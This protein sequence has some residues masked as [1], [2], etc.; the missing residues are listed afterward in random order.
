MRLRTHVA[1]FLVGLFSLAAAAAIGRAVYRRTAM[2]S[3]PVPVVV[4]ARDIEAYRVI[5]EEDVTVT[6]MAAAV[7]ALGVFR[8]TRDVVGLVARGH[9]PQGVPVL[10][11]LVATEAPYAAPEQA[12]LRLPVSP[13]R[14]PA[15]LRPG[16]RLDL[17]NGPRLL[18]RDVRVVAVGDGELTVAV[19]QRAVPEVLAAAERGTLW[20]VVAPQERLPVPSPTPT[21]TPTAT[22]TAT[23]T[24]TPTPT[25]TPTP[26]PVPHVRVR[27]DLVQRVNVR[28]GPGMDFP[29]IA[30]AAPGARF[31]LVGEEG[32]WTQVCCVG[33]VRGWIRSDLLED[34]P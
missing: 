26:T 1:M 19:D 18:A 20:P 30:Q 8:D 9:I 29:V 34:V 3:R 11:A 13:G 33:D 31:T 32:G 4:A 24:P 16:Q 27:L 5:R 12:L 22:P 14:M 21:P 25:S 17:W 7:Q 23:P 15:G 28:S 10:R 6:D 2:L